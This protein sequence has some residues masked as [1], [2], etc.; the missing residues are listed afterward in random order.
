[1]NK[2]RIF[3]SDFTLNLG[4]R[5]RVFEGREELEHSFRGLVRKMIL[6]NCV[7]CKSSGKYWEMTRLVTLVIELRIF[8]DQSLGSNG[9]MMRSK[10]PIMH[11]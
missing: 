3:T 7:G 6:L 1:M 5:K 8:A 11:Y 9:I 10:T 4:S 2:N